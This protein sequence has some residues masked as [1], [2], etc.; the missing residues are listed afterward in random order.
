VRKSPGDFQG[1]WPARP[2]RGRLR[3]APARYDDFTGDARAGDAP[4]T[5]VDVNR[6]LPD[7][8]PA[9]PVTG[10]ITDIAS[11]LVA[12]QARQVLARDILLRLVK[13]VGAYDPTAYLASA[14]WANSQPPTPGEIITL[15]WLAQLA[16]NIVDYI[17]SDD[18]STPFPW[19]QMT[20]T[21]SFAGLYGD[22]WVFG[23]ELPRVVLNEAYAEYVN[24]PG[25]TGKGRRATRF[26]VHVWLE[27][28]NPLISDPTLRDGGDA[29]LD[30]A[31][32]IVLSRFNRNL[33]S[34]TDMS[35][36]LG[37]P[38]GTG[39]RQRYSFGQVYTV[40]NSFSPAVLPTSDKAGRGFYVVGPMDPV[41]GVNA[42][43][44]GADFGTLR[45]ATMSY[46]EKVA[47]GQVLP[48]PA[49][50]DTAGIV[51]SE[52]VVVSEITSATFTGAF[53][54]A[55][56]QGFTSITAYGNPGPR[57]GAVNPA[58]EPAVVPYYTVIR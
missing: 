42:W 15:R 23:T 44:P 13:A 27:P 47:P 20:G 21:P 56:P 25:E 31:Y 28:Y 58:H 35:N 18:F 30:G 32:Q 4:L 36:V 22:E 39:P 6:A 41:S 10:Q 26:I 48:P 53:I 40:S 2:G 43:D 38:D 24:I 7:Y 55:Y 17:D 45:K 34:A 3:S 37:D 50:L 9:S 54:R 51:R 1:A 19:G 11:F 14:P 12:Q 29:R 46:V 8:P 49:G 16:V 57:A 52:D 33:L 5:R